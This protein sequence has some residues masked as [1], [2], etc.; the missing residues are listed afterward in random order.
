MRGKEKFPFLHALEESPQSATDVST[1]IE[2][3]RGDSSPVIG[4]L[5][6]HGSRARIIFL[7]GGADSCPT[8]RGGTAMRARGKRSHPLLMSGWA[9]PLLGCAAAISPLFRGTAELGGTSAAFFVQYIV[10]RCYFCLI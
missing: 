4:C 10:S 1:T 9:K 3:K 6:E 7:P 5:S 8:W 2:K